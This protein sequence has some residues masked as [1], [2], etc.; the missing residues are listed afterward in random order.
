MGAE[1]GNRFSSVGGVRDRAVNKGMDVH[2]SKAPNEEVPYAVRSLTGKENRYFLPR[3]YK[4]RHAVMEEV[5]G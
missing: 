5:Y 2:P 3:S 4:G 1:R